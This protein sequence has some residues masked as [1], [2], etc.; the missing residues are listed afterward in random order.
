MQALDEKSAEIA[1]EL[2]DAK[3]LRAEAEKVLSDYE[4]QRKQAEAQ[5]EKIMCRS[6]KSWPRRPQCRIAR[7]H[8][9]G[10]GAAHA[11]R[12]KKK[13]PALRKVLKKKCAPPLP[14]WRLMRQRAFG[15]QR[16]E[17]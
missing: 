14:H 15:G 10:D 1:K 12:R 9:S 6:Q 16:Y 4:E 5:A 17:R 3:A 2:D 7:R 11:N 13:L 8:A